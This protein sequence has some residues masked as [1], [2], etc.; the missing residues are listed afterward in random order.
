MDVGQPVMY[1][2][3]QRHSVVSGMASKIIRKLRTTVRKVNTT[4]ESVEDFPERSELDDDTEGFSARL[5]GTLSF[6][7][8]GLADEDC[9]ETAAMNSGPEFLQSF[10]SDGIDY[11]ESPLG[12]LKPSN[13]L[14]TQLQENWNKS[15]RNLIVEKLVFEVTSANVVHDSS[16]KYVGNHASSPNHPRAL[17]TL[18]RATQRV[19]T[20]TSSSKRRHIQ[21]R[22]PP[23]EQILT[24]RWDLLLGRFLGHSVAYTIHVIKS[25]SFDD[26]KALIIRRYTDF[27]KLNVEL[28]K[29]FKEEM[30]NVVFP[31]KIIRRNFT[32]ETIAKRSRAFEQY[33]QHIHSIADI[34][35]SKVFLEFFYLRDLKA[36][37]GL[38]RGGMCEDALETLVNAFHLQQ[39]LCSLDTE[40]LLFTQASI[41][42]CYQELDRL[43]EAQTYCEQAL[44]TIN[45]QENH[46]LLVP[47]L[48]SNIRLSW[49]IAK[50]KR[51]SE[52]KLQ[53]IQEAGIDVLNQPSLKE[54]LIKDFLE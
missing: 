7:D 41:S 10:E 29:H 39:K 6:G 48:H 25:G 9:C 13:M 45:N 53:Q 27:A 21:H 38:L 4:E 30:G 34:C 54:H 17:W 24:P 14:T 51:E 46:P 5:S 42:V 31:K 33:L 16:S 12:E 32:H 8:A 40:H 36:G 23:P 1:V 18:T 28:H 49:K 47:L 20:Q 52:A 26:N 15:R 50:D 3:S 2:E 44:Q 43:D 19:N 22:H 11:T 35:K 37:Q